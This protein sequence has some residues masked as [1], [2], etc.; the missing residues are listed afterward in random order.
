[1]PKL[2]GIRKCYVC[3]K[4]I[5]I[6]HQNRMKGNVTCSNTCKGLAARKEP[7]CTC[8]ICDSKFHLKPSKLKG[9]KHPPCCSMECASKLKVTAYAGKNNPNYLNRGANNP[10]HKGYRIIHAGYYYVYEPDHPFCEPTMSGRIREHRLVAE[11]HLLNEDNSV[12]INGVRY[13][14]PLFDVHH[15]DENKLNNEPDNL[16]VLSRSEHSLHHSEFREIVRCVTTG[17]IKGII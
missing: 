1:M 13:L 9:R 15:K 10:L 12:V 11:R 16:E 4:E 5:E 7:N 14:S 17:R 2:Y 3:E 8:P 6:Y